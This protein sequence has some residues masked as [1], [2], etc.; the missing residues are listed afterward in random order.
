MLLALDEPTLPIWLVTLIAAT[1]LL[2]FLGGLVGTWLTRKSDRESD[3]RWRREESMRMLRWATEL[4][5]SPDGEKASTG[6][7]VITAL[8]GAQMLDSDDLVFLDALTREDLA[9][10]LEN[11]S[12]DTLVEIEDIHPD[13]PRYPVLD[14][15]EEDPDDQGD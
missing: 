1:P 10:E 15:R 13:D 8:A 5:L 3:R 2:A 14:T 7:A 4:A 11:A 12:A 9:F 6:W